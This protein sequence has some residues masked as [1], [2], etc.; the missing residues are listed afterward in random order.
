M[1]KPRL[2]GAA[3]TTQSAVSL[4][5]LACNFD[6]RVC[7][8]ERMRKLDPQWEPVRSGSSVEFP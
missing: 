6:V 1:S 7:I 4:E 8:N 3:T 5:S 2:T